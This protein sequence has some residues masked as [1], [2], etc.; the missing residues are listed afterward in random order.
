[1]AARARP[2]ARAPGAQPAAASDVLEVVT[3]RDRRLLRAFLER[4]R[5]LSGYALCALD[6][7][8]FQHAHWGVALRDGDPVALATEQGGPAPQPVFVAGEPEAAELL[9]RRVIR[10]WT[11]YIAARP[12]LLSPIE[13]LYRLDKG[14][15]M[16][17]MAVDRERFRPY[18]GPV[19][20]LTASSVGELNRMYDLGFTSWLPGEAL[21]D[22]VYYGLRI[23][24]RLV[25]AAGTHAVSREA[26]LGI[27][28]N[29]MTILP[30]QGRGYAKATTSAVTAELRGDCDDVILNVRSDNPP[31]L[32][33]YRALGFREY[34]RFEERLARRRSGSWDV[35]IA[36]LRRFLGGL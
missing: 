4:D 26:R 9:L 23:G 7:R 14:P 33:A 12:E 16:V 20:R 29:V 21:V 1:M 8:P 15:Q 35:I 3:T 2:R 24:G 17:R 11:A 5:L 10:P 32:A 6:E 25:A 18:P 27:V 22:G 13:V 34:A 31:A 28:G 30:Y 36:P 19:Q